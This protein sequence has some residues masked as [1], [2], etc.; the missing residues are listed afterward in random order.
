MIGERLVGRFGAARPVDTLTAT[1]L[2]AWWVEPRATL[3]PMMLLATCAACAPSATRL[4]ADGL[5][6]PACCAP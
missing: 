3:A 5:R 2:R 1:E 4:S 6:P